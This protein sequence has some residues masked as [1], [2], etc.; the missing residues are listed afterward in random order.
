M[1]FSKEDEIEKSAEVV[2]HAH[3]QGI[4]Y[5]DT[6]PGYCADK[7]EDIYGHALKQL[8]RN[9]FYISTKCGQPDANVFR[10]SLERSLERLGVEHIDFFHVWG[11][12]TAGKWEAFK[13]EGAFDELLKARDEGLVGHV[14]FSTHMTHEEAD[15]VFEEGVFEGVTLGYNVINFPFREH[16]LESAGRHGLGVVT[17]NPLGGGLIPRHA[18]LFDF[19]RSEDDPYVVSAALRFILSHPAVTAALVG[20]SCEKEVDEAVA[21]VKRFKP[22]STEHR[23][24]LKKRVANNFEGLCTGCGY[25]LPCPEG[26]PIPRL[27]ETYNQW[28]LQEAKGKDMF[29]HLKYYWGLTPED[30]ARCVAC[31][32]CE[33]ACTQHL[34]IIERLKEI[35]AIEPPEE[36]K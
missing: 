29:Y 5:F 3:A 12:Q 23:E 11:L 10:S 1:R 31:G 30:A 4:T 8:P 6:A 18:K 9:S 25:C 16:V 2:L 32:A 20:F 15:S 28:I 35:A 24:A 27:M 17:M 21:A 14:V 33:K 36:Q 19:I 34:P 13:K 26:L 7:S 22:L